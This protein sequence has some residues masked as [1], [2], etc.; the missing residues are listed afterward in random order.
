MKYNIIGILLQ[1]NTISRTPITRGSPDSLDR[2]M[3]TDEDD[4][5]GSKLWMTQYSNDF[6]KKKYERLNS[7]NKFLI[8]NFN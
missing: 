4:K 8:S 1:T 6:R 5:R 2:E 3:T 7:V